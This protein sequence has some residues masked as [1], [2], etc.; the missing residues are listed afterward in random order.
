MRERARLNLSP[1]NSQALA[2]GRREAQTRGVPRVGGGGV[3]YITIRTI[4]HNRNLSSWSYNI[5][6]LLVINVFKCP[7]NSLRLQKVTFGYFFNFTQ[8]KST[9]PQIEAFYIS[10]QLDRS[11]LGSTK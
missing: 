2:S 4:C 9:Y 1:R 8:I 7:L 3:L 6:Q 10:H 11:S 5:D